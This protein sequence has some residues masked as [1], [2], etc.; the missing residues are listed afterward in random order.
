[1]I[2][3]CIRFFIPASRRP[4]ACQKATSSSM[5]PGTLMDLSLD[6]TPVKGIGILVGRG[7]EESLVHTIER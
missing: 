2:F 3:S 7:C 6:D 1:M 4:I 5:M